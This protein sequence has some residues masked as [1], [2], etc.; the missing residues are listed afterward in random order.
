MSMDS[1]I[2]I[3]LPRYSRT[4]VVSTDV[5]TGNIETRVAIGYQES[6]VS[7]FHVQELVTPQTGSMS[8]RFVNDIFMLLNQKRLDKVT[9]QALADFIED[10]SSTSAQS[11][12]VS[13]LKSKCTDEQLMQYCKSRYIQS[14]Q[15]LLAWSQHLE[16]G[17]SGVLA[18]IEAQK[19][20]DTESTET[21]PSNTSE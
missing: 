1:P 4:T 19:T 11:E 18:E 16:N 2:R 3:E 14:P 6:T 10:S 12:F 9:L 7:S 17:L 21:Q 13:Q 15:E 5:P 8:V 20:V